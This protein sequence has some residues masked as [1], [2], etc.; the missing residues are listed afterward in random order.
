MVYCIVHFEELPPCQWNLSKFV[1]LSNFG[2][3]N[4]QHIHRHVK[5]ENLTRNIRI[6]RARVKTLG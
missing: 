4:F 1:V 2:G 6:S 5:P 3:G